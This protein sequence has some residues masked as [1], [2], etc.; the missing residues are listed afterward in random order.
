M[1][2]GEIYT[3]VEDNLCTFAF[4]DIGGTEGLYHY[5]GVNCADEVKKFGDRHSSGCMGYGEA[6]LA[7]IEEVERFKR[8]LKTNDYHWNK[9]NKKV[10]RISTGELL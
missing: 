4:R 2:D 1:I 7:T 9:A 3:K 5:I 8:L 10:I 6:R